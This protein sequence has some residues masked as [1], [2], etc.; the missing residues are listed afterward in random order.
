[1]QYY[2]DASCTNM[3]L[4]NA[5]KAQ[6]CV[7][8]SESTYYGKFS[9]AS[10]TST[11]AT[12]QVKIYSDNKCSTSAYVDTATVTTVPLTCT[13]SGSGSYYK[14]SISSGVS[15][16]TP[17]NG[18]SGAYIATYNTPA[19][20]KANTMKVPAYISSYQF[21]PIGFCIS[22]TSLSDSE[23]EY[24]VMMTDCSGKSSSFEIFT[25]TDGS[26]SGDVTEATFKQRQYCNEVGDIYGL[27]YGYINFKCTA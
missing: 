8:I 7:A 5:F 11:S 16:L 17:G 3:I 27:T 9:L 26:C 18:I 10:S 4:T 14:A 12:V 21:F 23:S 19:H 1:M 24:D 25:S 22:G 15:T 6:K 13:P 2:S 20:C